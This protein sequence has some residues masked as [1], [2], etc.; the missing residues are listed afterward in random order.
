MIS[1]IFYKL[2]KKASRKN[3]HNFIKL[4]I[5]N[6]INQKENTKVLDIIPENHP[7]TVDETI[8]KVKNLNFKF[9]R[10]K[11]LNEKER[12]NG[13]IFLSVNEMENNL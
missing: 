13:D 1:R 8:A 7:N 10:T 4:S 3:L 11:E 6:R 5:D 9:I 2:S 12:V